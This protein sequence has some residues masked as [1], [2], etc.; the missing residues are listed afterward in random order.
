MVAIDT[1][2]LT[3]AYAFHRDPRQA[4]NAQFLTVVQADDPATTIYTVMELLGKLSFNLSG[5]RLARWP[6]WLQ[7]HYQLT[8]LYP[9]TMGLSAEVFFNS[10]FVDQP[11]RKMQRF[12][13]PFLGFPDPESSRGRT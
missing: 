6:S 3:L 4:A 12:Q 11:F 7:E 9:S 8:I 2:V 1:D 5:E 13:M 10:E